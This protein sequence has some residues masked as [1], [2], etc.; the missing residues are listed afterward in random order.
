[1]EILVVFI[2]AILGLIIGSSIEGKH[3][4]SLDEREVNFENVPCIMNKKFP[5]RE[6]AQAR[7]V[8]GS[9]VIS[10]DKFK[11]IMTGFRMIFGGE[12]K[13]Y[14]PLIERA[15]REAIL[16]MKEQ[17]PGADM[18][19]G[20]RLETSTISAGAEGAMGTVEVLAYGTALKFPQNQA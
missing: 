4:K 9:V 8:S 17:A 13:S 12:L 2:L 5:N 14:A 20:V 16:R 1:M 19:V 7:L 15:R 3:F 11:Q 10:I 6:V 18:Y